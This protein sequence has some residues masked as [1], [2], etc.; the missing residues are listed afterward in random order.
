MAIYKELLLLFHVSELYV[1][2]THRL[3]LKT[4]NGED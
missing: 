3:G 1:V 4:S 2:K